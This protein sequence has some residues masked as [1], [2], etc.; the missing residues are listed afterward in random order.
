[1]PL[2]WKKKQMIY[3]LIQPLPY[4]LWCPFKVFLLFSFSYGKHQ[5]C[6]K[7]RTERKDIAT[8]DSSVIDIYLYIRNSYA[9]KRVLKVH[10]VSD[11]HHR[12]IYSHT[13]ASLYLE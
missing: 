13:E 11:P 8:K 2:F 12:Y 9:F 6:R 4:V 3:K 1:M 7:E 10:M 5:G